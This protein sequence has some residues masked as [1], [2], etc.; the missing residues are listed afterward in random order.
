MTTN[1]QQWWVR[2]L[3]FVYTTKLIQWLQRLRD[4]AITD[5]GQ[6]LTLNYQS[7]NSNR[8]NMA[9]PCTHKAANAYR[10]HLSLTL[11]HLPAVIL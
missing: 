1:T 7:A 3:L 10:P 2:T 8:S 9:I 4:H 6:M 11:A 5:Q